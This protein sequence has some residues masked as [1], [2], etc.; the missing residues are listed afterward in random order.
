MSFLKKMTD[1][2]EDLVGDKEKKKEESHKGKARLISKILLLL[3]HISQKKHEMKPIHH[4]TPSRN[5]VMAL[6]LPS[7]NRTLGLLPRFLLAG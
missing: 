5:M 2:F 6:R 4:I 3:N 7:S 1:K